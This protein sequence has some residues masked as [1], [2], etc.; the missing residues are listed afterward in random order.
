MGILVA[1]ATIVFFVVGIFVRAYFHDE[2][3]RKLSS[4]S[5]M[6][7]GESFVIPKD[8]EAERAIRASEVR[9]FRDM[10]WI[11]LPVCMSMFN[12][13]FFHWF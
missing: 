10:C 13:S 6:I 8:R 9:M 5:E 11:A 3:A 4:R 1:I 12:L 7:G 2:F